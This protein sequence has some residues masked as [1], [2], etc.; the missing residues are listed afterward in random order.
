MPA[1]RHAGRSP[2]ARGPGGWSPARAGRAA[3]WACSPRRSMSSSAAPADRDLV[4][5]ETA[6]GLRLPRAATLAATSRARAAARPSGRAT[7]RR[8]ASGRL[9]VGP[10]AFDVVRW[11]SPR[12]PRTVP[13]PYDDARL[14]PCRGCC[15]RCLQN[16][17]TGSVLPD[18]RARGPAARRPA[19]PPWPPC[20]G[21]APA[22]PR[23]VTTCSPACS[24]RSPQRQHP[25]RSRVGSVTS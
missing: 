14:T 10:L 5:L 2:R 3:S 16:S 12:R 15:P 20:S 6:D 24:S 21:W 1:P 17:E 7:R 8:S 25:D 22:S 9:D 11:W 18:R 19:Q 4:A 23:R 13:T